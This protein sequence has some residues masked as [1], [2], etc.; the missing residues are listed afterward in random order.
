MPT[1]VGIVFIIGGLLV[2]FSKEKKEDEFI[3]NLRLSSL[4]WAVCVNYVLL[5]LAF[6]F[7]YGMGFFTVMAY[8]LFTVLLIFI[9]RFNYIVY[10]NTKIVSDEK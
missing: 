8:N 3:A 1:L 10:K 7:V 6:V 9:S 4:L 5:F 2:G